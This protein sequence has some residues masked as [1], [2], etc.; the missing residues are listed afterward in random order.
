MFYGRPAAA[1]VDVLSLADL[2]FSHPPHNREAV[3]AHE[4]VPVEAAKRSASA[5]IRRTT[6]LGRECLIR[7]LRFDRGL[8][9]AGKLCR[10]G[11]GI[12]PARPQEKSLCCGDAILPQIST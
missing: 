3:G 4:R 7:M 9:R 6:V 1:G 8:P 11:L 12:P 2:R 10:R 5:S